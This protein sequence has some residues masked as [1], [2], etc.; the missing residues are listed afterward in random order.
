MWQSD[1]LKQCWTKPTRKKVKDSSGQGD[2]GPLHETNSVRCSSTGYGRAR[3]IRDENA[4]SYGGGRSSTRRYY[5][6]GG[7][8]HPP[9]RTWR[10]NHRPARTWRQTPRLTGQRLRRLLS[11]SRA[12]RGGTAVRH[13]SQDQQ[14]G[15]D[16][17]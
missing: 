16:Y 17:S 5:A 2:G 6:K 13:R 11:S 8:E 12:P 7:R 15:N 10:A 1:W 4:S 3:V 9:P 14:S